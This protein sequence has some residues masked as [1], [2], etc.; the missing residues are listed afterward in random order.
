VVLPCIE[1]TNNN[2]VSS[3]TKNRYELNTIKEN[4]PLN[5]V[6]SK[7]KIND[8][9]PKMNEGSTRIN[10]KIQSIQVVTSKYSI[11]ARDNKSLNKFKSKEKSLKSEAKDTNKRVDNNSVSP[12]KILR[13]D[14]LSEEAKSNKMRKLISEHKIIVEKIKK[15]YTVDSS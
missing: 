4:I 13:S 9:P 7:P 14:V 6:A 5:P 12:N 11:F 3:Y 15:I 10:P 2:C 8:N 1:K